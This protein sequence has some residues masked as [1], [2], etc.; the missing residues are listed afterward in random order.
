MREFAG[1]MF[2]LA[3][4]AL[5]RN[6]R[7]LIFV[8]G[9]CLLIGFGVMYVYDVFFEIVSVYTFIREIFSLH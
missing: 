5:K 4:I 1:D 8:L 7:I 6:R 9:I 2:T 3:T